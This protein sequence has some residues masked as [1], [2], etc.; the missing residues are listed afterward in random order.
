M[1]LAAEDQERLCDTL[2][3]V[4]AAD[5][6][7]AAAY[8]QV[9]A[10]F[11]DAVKPIYAWLYCQAARVHGVSTD[12]DL[13][14]FARTFRDSGAARACFTAR[15]WDFGEVEYTYL[16]R[17]AARRP[18]VLPEELGP[19]YA[20]KGEAFLLERSR[21]EEEAGRGDGAITVGE[22]LLR[23]LPTSTAGHDRLA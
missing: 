23:L 13:D 11:P 19:D 4:H 6:A 21:Q 1:T 15:G 5:L 3:A 18:G 8:A 12:Q 2:A 10:T 7:A 14:L 16:E 17:C 22:V 9:A 20:V